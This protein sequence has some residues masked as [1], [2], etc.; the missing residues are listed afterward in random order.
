VH[1][2]SDRGS[3]RFGKWRY[4]NGQA[5]IVDT[6]L[7]GVL[8]PHTISAV[9]VATGSDF[10]KDLTRNETGEFHMISTIVPVRIVS[11]KRRIP[12]DIK[13]DNSIDL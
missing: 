11:S 12:D 1:T 10:R 6:N 13:S 9:C 2:S 8:H 4:G 5:E 7:C 3:R